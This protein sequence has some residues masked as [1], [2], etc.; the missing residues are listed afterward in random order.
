MKK[1]SGFALSGVRMAVCAGAVSA[2]VFALAALLPDAVFDV[3]FCRAPAHLAGAYFGVSADGAAFTLADGRVIAVTRACGGAGFFAMLCGL[4]ACRAG[5]WRAWP[6]AVAA[7]WGYA[8]CVN[9]VRI[10]GT[11]WVRAFAEAALP[12]RFWGVAHLT[13]GV[14]VFFPALAA[15]WWFM[16]KGLQKE[17]RYER[18]DQ[19][20]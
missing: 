5:N 13:T 10:V 20:G 9:G 18:G 15:A 8:V 3:V 4:L 19:N 17:T 11:V 7:V 2:A 16:T 6:A 12:E 1:A 14:M